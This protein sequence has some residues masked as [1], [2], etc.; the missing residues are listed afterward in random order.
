MPERARPP[1]NAESLDLKAQRAMLEHSKWSSDLTLIFRH[2]DRSTGGRS[3][4]L[5]TDA[6]AVEQSGYT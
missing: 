3:V 2:P 4:A 5:V 6:S 1:I